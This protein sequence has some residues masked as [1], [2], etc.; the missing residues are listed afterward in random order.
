MSSTLRRVCT[1]EQV[2]WWSAVALAHTS[3]AVTP[4]LQSTQFSEPSVNLMMSKLFWSS[5]LSVRV[6]DRVGVKMGLREGKEDDGEEEGKEDDGE[7]D[8]SRVGE[9][10]L[11][12]GPWEGKAEVGRTVGSTIGLA[13]GD[14]VASKSSLTT[15]RE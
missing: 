2:T 5:K 11:E 12:V 3:H 1:T 4:W 15:L 14:H 10:G 7:A 13:E 9:A 8:G 6:G